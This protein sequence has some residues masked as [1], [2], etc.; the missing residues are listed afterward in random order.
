M[1]SLAHNRTAAPVKTG[2]QVRALVLP[3]SHW[4]PASA[5]TTHPPESAA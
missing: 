3:A 1:G 5:G 4:I 2:A